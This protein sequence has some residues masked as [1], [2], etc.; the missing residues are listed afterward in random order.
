VSGMA[1]KRSQQLY[2]QACILM[3]AGVNSPVRAFGSVHGQP[4]F[5]QSGQSAYLKDVDGNRYLDCCGS[6]G[7]LILGHGHPVVLAAVREI[8]EN[9]LTFGAPH[10]GEMKLA[11][12]VIQSYPAVEQVR[13]VN[14]GT[15]AVM[16]ALRLARGATG[17]SLIVKFSGCYH[18]HSDCML[19]EGGS[20]LATFGTSSSAGVP[21][22]AVADTCV[23]P[24]D[25]EQVVEDLF[26]SRGEDIA[27]VVIEPIPANAGLLLQ[28]EE[29]LQFL[30]QITQR[31]GAL[32]VL[33]EVIS[34]FRVGLGGAAARY[35]LEPDL[36]TFGKVIGGGL[37]VGAFGGKRELMAHIAPL[38]PVYQAGTLSGNPVA[39]AAGLATLRVL[40]EEDVYSRLEDLGQRFEREVT[41]RLKEEGACCARIGS[42]FWLAF[43]PKAP[44][45]LETIEAEGM[46]R[47]AGFHAAMLE[48]EIYLAPSGYEVG[49]LN[50]AMDEQ[51]ITTLVDAI[52][53]SLTVVP[54]G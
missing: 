48:R 3:P 16:S 50:A 8:C 10:E 27:A 26:Q 52:D 11:E 30:R 22:G 23:L 42:I 38:G 33:D 1:R 37:P 39:M 15:E 17:R 7:P 51:D 2:E 36:V 43:Q 6:W 12:A 53:S 45:S 25:D 41:P 34:G 31:F 20:G 14:S 54:R 13:F 35:G 47:Y 44:R 28:R 4:L 18:G 21:T 40:C 49:F 32:L 24:L 9:G 29:Y 46:T 5:I 19:V